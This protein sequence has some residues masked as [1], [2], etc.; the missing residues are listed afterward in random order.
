MK[1]IISAKEAISMIKDGSSVMVGGFISC[2]APDVLVDE[3]VEQN[4]SNE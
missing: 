1:E 3:L 4:V 2:G